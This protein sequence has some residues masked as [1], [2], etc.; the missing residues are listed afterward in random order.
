MFM[1]RGRVLTP[2]RRIEGIPNSPGFP[3][4]GKSKKQKA[5]GTINILPL[6]GWGSTQTLL[7]PP[8]VPNTQIQQA[9]QMRAP[10]ALLSPVLIDEAL[11]KLVVKEIP[12]ANA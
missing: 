2:H 9:P 10:V 1:D 7:D 3:Q 12:R 4:F 11:D 6:R 8:I 5:R